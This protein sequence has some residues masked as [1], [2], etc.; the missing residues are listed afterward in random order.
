MRLIKPIRN[1][2]FILA[3]RIVFSFIS[4]STFCSHGWGMMIFLFLV[5]GIVLLFLSLGLL[6]SAVYHLIVQINRSFMCE[7]RVPKSDK[8]TGLNALTFTFGCLIFLPQLQW[9]LFWFTLTLDE[10]DLFMD[11]RWTCCIALPYFDHF[12]RRSMV[13]MFLNEHSLL[14]YLF[15]LLIWVLQDLPVFS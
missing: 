4:S 13:I 5:K 8:L 10:Y 11:H 1:R 14:R 9:V 7:V 3:R 15:D 12:S 2:T 6:I